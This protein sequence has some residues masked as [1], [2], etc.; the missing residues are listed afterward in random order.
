M[1]HRFFCGFLPPLLLTALLLTGCG[2][3]K[4][5]DVCSPYHAC[6]FEF[7]G[8]TGATYYY[9]GKRCDGS[10][11]IVSL[12]SRT[13]LA[14]TTCDKD[15]CPGQCVLIGSF[16]G[17][18]EQASDKAAKEEK[19]PKDHLRGKK[20]GKTYIYTEAVEPGIP[21]AE[22]KR[23]KTTDIITN[24]EGCKVREA[25]PERFVWVELTEKGDKRIKAELHTVEV[26]SNS[27]GPART[28]GF[29][30]EWMV[31]SNLMPA[32]S[33][34]SRMWRSRHGGQGHLVK[35]DGIEY[36]VTLHDGK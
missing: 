27:G 23:N 20:I 31:R 24:H 1:H 26:T 29:G 19:R 5:K 8:K 36:L 34:S 2:R 17:G 35:D 10:N 21:K 28:M 9:N 13:T 16:S 22:C 7:V 11:N 12:A 4:P 3:D 14:L 6:P 25:R 15:P 30:N 18:E 33:S 32:R